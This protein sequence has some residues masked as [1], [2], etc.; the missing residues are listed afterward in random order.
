MKAFTDGEMFRETS[1]QAGR[2]AGGIH[3]DYADLQIGRWMI[4][5][6]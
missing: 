1:N 4:D 3:R 5:A 2:R 6:Y